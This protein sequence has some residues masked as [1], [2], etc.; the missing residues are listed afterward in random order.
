ML[1]KLKYF[2]LLTGFYSCENGTTSLNNSD[3]L[4]PN[5]LH[6]NIPMYSYSD[7]LGNIF[8]V[9]GDTIYFTGIPDTLNSAPLLAWDSINLNIITVA[10]FKV[11]PTILGSTLRNP[12]DIIWQWHSGMNL[13]KIKGQVKYSEGRNVINDSI[14]YNAEALP[15]S[16][17]NYSWAVWSWSDDGTSIL[18]SSRIMSFYVPN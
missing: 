6:L 3:L 7:G 8:K 4:F 2:I 17:G 5:S 14:E 12:G 16:K 18:F 15:L 10:I 13:Q 1:R 9:Q 11:R